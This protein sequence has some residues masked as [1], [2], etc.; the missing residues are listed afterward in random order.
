MW[1]LARSARDVRGDSETFGIENEIV[2]GILWRYAQEPRAVA[3]RLRN[4]LAGSR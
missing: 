3:Q 1:L 4:R 2:K